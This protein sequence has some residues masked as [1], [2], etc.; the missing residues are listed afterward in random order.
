MHLTGVL[1]DHSEERTRAGEEMPDGV[2]RP[3]LV[4]EVKELRIWR[5]RTWG[6]R[7]GPQDCVIFLHQVS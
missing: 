6:S 5:C 4:E 2:K 3:S 7:W 1:G